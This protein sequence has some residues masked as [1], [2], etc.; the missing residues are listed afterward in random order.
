MSTAYHWVTDYGVGNVW[1]SV[2]WSACL[3]I[4]IHGTVLASLLFPATQ[5]SPRTKWSHLLLA[6]MSQIGT[7][8]YAR[9][10][11]H[12]LIFSMSTV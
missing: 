1:H 5:F 10:V 12:I 7:C 9:L 3:P 2:S 8:L 11:F 4:R 6:K